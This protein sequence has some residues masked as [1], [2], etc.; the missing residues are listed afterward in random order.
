VKKIFIALSVL[1]LV[2]LTYETILSFSTGIGGRT[3][4]NSYGEPEFGCSCHNVDS[5]NSVKVR[6]YGPSTVAPG[7]VYTYMVTMKGGPAVAGGLDFNCWYGSVDT[8]GGQQTQNF[9]FDITHTQ[10]KQ[11]AGSDSVSWLVKYIAK[12]TNTI[13][14]DTLYAASNSVNFNGIADSLDRWNWAPNF[15]VKIDP[16]TIG[17]ENGGSIASLFS[18]AQNYPNPFNP[19]TNIRFN[20]ST[21]G[22]VSLKIYNSL[23]KEIAVL[24]NSELRE[25]DYS[26]QW[27]AS[28]YPS[29]IYF[30]RLTS[31]SGSVEKKMVLVK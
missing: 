8:V 23:G 14:Y 26:M 12:D 27:N 31:G 4:K 24:V 13:I 17:I 11:F 21:A 7:F 22:F 29:G 25:G 9:G 10:P 18:L 6:I 5:L 16:A 2:T 3:R 20:L 15:V 28:N 19:E 30:Y 1:L